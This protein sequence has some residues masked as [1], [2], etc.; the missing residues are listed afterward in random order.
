MHKGKKLHHV[1][2]KSGYSLS[3]IAQKLYMSRNTFYAKLKCEEP[4]E[5]FILALEK[6]LNCNL[7]F[8]F[9]DVKRPLYK[10]KLEKIRRF[11]RAYNKVLEQMIALMSLAIESI[12]LVKTEEE[13]LR[14]TKFIKE[15]VK[16]KE[17]LLEEKP[18]KKRAKDGLLK[19]G[20]SNQKE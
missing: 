8:L 11:E 18:S 2:K 3:M 19:R 12:I 6:A 5:E 16:M 7:S 1:L 20:S 13:R 9:P 4:S 15:K 14:I 17:R 10:E